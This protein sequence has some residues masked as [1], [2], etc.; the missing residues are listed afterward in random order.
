MVLDGMGT[1]EIAVTLD[2]DNV[3]TPLNYWKERGLPR[4]G[5]YSTKSPSHWN[6]STICSIISRQE[7]CGDVINFKTYSKSYKNK[8]RLKNSPENTLT[9]KDVHEPIISRDIFEKLQDKRGTTRK[10]KKQNGEKNIFSGILICADCG[11]NL[12]FHFNQGNNNIKYFNCSNYNSS[13]GT[14]NSTH[15]IRVDFLEKVVSAEIQ[16][17]MS[18][19]TEYEKEFAEHM[20]NCAVNTSNKDKN[21]IERKIYTLIERNDTLD[22]LFESLYEDNVSGKISDERF[23]KMSAKY[24]LEQAQLK[25][26]IIKLQMELDDIIGKEVTVDAFL[27]TVRQFINVT[28]LTSRIINELIEKIEVHQAVKNDGGIYEQKLTIHYHCVGAFTIPDFP[29]SSFKSIE[30]TTRKGVQLRNSLPEKN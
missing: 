14:C 16:R 21:V 22:R 23:A 11:H 12:N 26:N 9:F 24:E 27:Q 10:R 3:L 15:Y 13:R 28:K 4:G 19:A 30:M 6:S 18:F 8:K 29:K 5:N 1:E 25:P 17:L 2:N 7:Y 20:M